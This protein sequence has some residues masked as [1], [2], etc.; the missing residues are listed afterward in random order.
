M[1]FTYI[2]SLNCHSNPM[3][4]N[5]IVLILQTRRSMHRAIKQFAQGYT[6]SKWQS[7]LN[8]VSTNNIYKVNK[9]LVLSILV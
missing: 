5:I 9:L 8:Q 3:R 1:N 2:K 7:Y 4:V 6:A